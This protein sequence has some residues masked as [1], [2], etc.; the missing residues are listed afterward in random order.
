MVAAA[1]AGGTGMT[2]RW[3]GAEPFTA[4][5]DAARAGDEASFARLW[6]WLHPALV[7]YLRV[8]DPADF[9][10]VASETWLSVARDLDRFSGD[11]KDFRAWVFTIAR[12]RA[13][14]LARRRQRRPRQTDDLDGL[15]LGAE[16]DAS[17][18]VMAAAELAD[19]LAALQALPPPQAEVVALRVIAGMTVAEVAAA[20]GKREGTVRVLAHR[21][22]RQLAETLGPTSPAV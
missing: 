19:A 9:E 16:G 18:P 1:P 21:G 3:T 10:D 4:V 14:D 6:R 22:L 15:D 20:T 5:L 17:E 13:I 8:V 11:D 2:G 7:R 12:H